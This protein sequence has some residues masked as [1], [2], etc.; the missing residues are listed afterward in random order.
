MDDSTAVTIYQS[1][2]QAQGEAI[3]IPGQQRMTLDQVIATWLDAK[4]K[5]TLSEKTAH[6]YRDTIQQFRDLLRAG[7]LDSEPAM[8]A[9]LTQ[10]YAGQSTK[11]EEVS[12]AT[13]KQRLAI[14]SSFYT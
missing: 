7:G 10:G 3:E 9:T 4:A 12:P 5:R 2:E 1:N 6:A 11:G 14:L 13:F 8:V